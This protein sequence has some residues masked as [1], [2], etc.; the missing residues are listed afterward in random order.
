MDESILSAEITTQSAV[1]KDAALDPL[2]ST[3]APAGSH[4]GLPSMVGTLM[5]TFI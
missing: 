2:C 5:F 3:D 4:T 1:P